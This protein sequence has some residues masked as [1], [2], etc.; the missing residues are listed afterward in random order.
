MGCGEFITTEARRFLSHGVV[1]ALSLGRVYCR[2][3]EKKWVFF[4]T[5]N[6]YITGLLEKYGGKS[7]GSFFLGEA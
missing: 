1:E 3:L 5:S 6:V 2:V 4:L 7:F